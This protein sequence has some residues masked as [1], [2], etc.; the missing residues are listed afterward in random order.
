MSIRRIWTALA[1]TALAL[2]AFSAPA[3]A[4]PHTV[5]AAPSGCTTSVEWVQEG[6][7]V[8]YYGRGKVHCTTGRYRAKAQCRNEQSGEGYVVYGTQVVSAPA[9]ATVT[10][11][12][13]NVAE[14]VFA[15]QDPPPSGTSGCASWVEWVHQGSNH[16]YGRAS[17]QCDTGRYRVKA[18][19]RNEQSGEGYVVYGTQVV[20]APA[21]ATVTC[22]TGNVAETVAAV[23]DPPASGTTGC[24]TWREWVT[25][26]NSHYYGRG[27]AQCDTGQY[28]AEVSCHNVQTGQD[29]VRYGAVTSAP[30]QA[31]VLCMSGNVAQSVVAV[32]R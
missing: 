13:G 26:Y 14:A 23:Q 6:T 3:Q 4:S 22:N 27:L 16:F 5:Q 11:N 19:C 20:S 1:V 2:C 21:E 29:Y 10:C 8:Y 17:V 24:V 30:A 25:E 28:Q 9:E 12:T 18:Q 32:P 31:S 15:V 7:N